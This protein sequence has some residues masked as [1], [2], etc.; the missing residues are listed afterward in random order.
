ME[1][2]RK[3]DIRWH[4]RD[5]GSKYFQSICFRKSN[6]TSA[7]TVVSTERLIPCK[8]AWGP[9]TLYTLSSPPRYGAASA[10]SGC[11]FSLAQ[12]CH[13]RQQ[14]NGSQDSSGPEVE[15]IFEYQLYTRNIT[16]I[17]GSDKDPPNPMWQMRNLQFIEVR[18]YDW[19]QTAREFHGSD[20]NSGLTT[21]PIFFQL[22]HAAY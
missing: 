20:L 9:P 13:V 22:H 15:M 5:K 8:G 19:D 21:K 3:G 11:L 7:N 14:W 4:Q 12:G 17:I 6:H 18:Y 2:E 10:E 16:C 1:W